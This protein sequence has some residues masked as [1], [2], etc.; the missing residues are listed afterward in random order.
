MIL[1]DPD[2]RLHRMIDW[3]KLKIKKNMLVV[4]WGHILKNLSRSD[5]IWQKKIIMDF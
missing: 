2:W 5:I 4:A 1:M 3:V